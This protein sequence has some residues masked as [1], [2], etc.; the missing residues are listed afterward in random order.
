MAKTVQTHVE[1]QPI[2]KLDLYTEATNPN[3]APTVHLNYVS[4]VGSFLSKAIHFSRG[5][6]KMLLFTFAKLKQLEKSTKLS[7]FF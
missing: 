7:A 3:V 1:F 5:T 6:L 4:N 2:G